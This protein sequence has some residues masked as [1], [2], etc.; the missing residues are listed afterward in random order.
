MYKKALFPLLLLIILV[1]FVFHPFF[2]NQL[3]HTDDGEFHAARS[4]NYYLAL[5]QGQ[6]PV[7]WAPNLSNNY[8]YPVFIFMYHIPYAL[9]VGMFA[10]ARMPFQLG[11]NFVFVG[12][13]IA[14]TIGMW[15]WAHHRGL[16]SWTAT[17]TAALYTFAPYSLI[18]IFARGAFGEVVFFGLLPWVF[19]TLDPLTQSTKSTHY[20]LHRIALIIL[21][22]ALVLTHPASL[23]TAAPLISSYALF[24]RR[25]VEQKIPIRWLGQMGMLAFIAGLLT[26][27]F[28]LPTI[29]EK[30]FVVLNKHTTVINYWKD[31]SPVRQTVF[32]SLWNNSITDSKKT[33]TLGYPLLLVILITLFGFAQ[34]RI[35]SPKNTLFWLEAFLLALFLTLPISRPVWDLIPTLQFMQFPWR[36]LWMTTFAGAMLFIEVWKTIQLTQLQKQLWAG[37]LSLLTIISIFNY[38]RYRGTQQWP[39]YELLEY[40]KQAS[41]YDEHQPIWAAEFTAKYPDQRLSFRKPGEKYFVDDMPNPAM[42][43]TSTELRWNGSVMQYKVNSDEPVEVVQKTYYFPGWQVLIDGQLTTIQYEDQEFPGHIIFTVPS[44]EHLIDV[45]FTNDTLDRRIGDYGFVVGG[46]A[47]AGYSVFLLTQNRKRLI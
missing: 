11:M 3:I 27:W 35:K 17:L 1:G 21:A 14:G 36:M 32:P 7:R 34:K 23:L 46:L 19:I 26:A 4:A 47:F 18:N 42:N 29:V 15:I 13:M 38:G 20:P 22:A 33:V 41:S 6:L 40:F 8:G 39:D 5:K 16:H 9:V 10:I 28:W 43:A 30:E 24:R 25:K 44:G 31:F 2:K 37:T 12:S 45:R